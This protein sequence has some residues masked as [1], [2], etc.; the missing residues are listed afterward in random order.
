MLKHYKIRKKIYINNLL[1]RS[2]DI[3]NKL[4]MDVGVLDLFMKQLS[5]GSLRLGRNLLRLVTYIEGGNFTTIIVGGK[6]ARHHPDESGLASPVL[7][8]QDQDLTV[9]E[10]SR[11]N[12]KLEGLHRLVHVR[13]LVAEI[14]LA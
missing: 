5:H 4:W 11:S 8:K 2:H 3:P 13:I 1:E 7:A 6:L 10:V 9:G 12:L 14:E